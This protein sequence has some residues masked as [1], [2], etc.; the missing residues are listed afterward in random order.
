[1]EAKRKRKEIP[2]QRVGESKKKRKE[3]PNQRVGESKKKRKKIPNQRMGE[4]KKRKERKFFIKETRRNVQKG[5]LTRQYL[6]NTELSPSKQEKKGN[7]DLKWS[8]PF[9]CRQNPVR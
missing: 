5:L 1:S 2:N 7:H 8:S 4:S 9:D 6:N 3:I